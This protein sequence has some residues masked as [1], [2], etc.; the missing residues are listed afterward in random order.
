MQPTFAEEVQSKWY[1]PDISEKVAIAK[2]MDMAF[3]IMRQDEEKKSSWTAFNKSKSDVNPEQTSLG[4]LPIIQA[5]AHEYDT[6][7]TAIQRCMHIS[8]AMGQHH[9]VITVDQAL[10]C[11]LM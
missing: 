2:A 8:N 1:E 10:Y 6:L 11:K 9:T 7:H 4:F 3:T 5:P